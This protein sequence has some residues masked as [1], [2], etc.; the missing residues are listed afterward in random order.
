MQTVI[1]SYTIQVVNTNSSYVV[2]KCRFG[3]NYGNMKTAKII[4]STA[5]NHIPHT[6]TYIFTF[7]YWQLIINAVV[8]NACGYVQVKKN[9]FVFFA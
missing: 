3:K 5:L 4:N 1:C 9:R 8:K 2:D 7:V 6:Q